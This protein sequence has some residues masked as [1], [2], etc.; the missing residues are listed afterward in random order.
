MTVAVVAFDVEMVA[1]SVLARVDD[2]SYL[3]YS[4]VI[5]SFAFAN[6]LK[7]FFNYLDSCRQRSL[8]AVDCQP[9]NSAMIMTI[10]VT[11]TTVMKVAYSA[12]LD[13]VAL[14]K[15]VK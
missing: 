7:V 2:S 15:S 8:I 14:V 3:R 6:G 10:M 4:V 12:L 9:S 13:S 11:L 1:Y 5:I